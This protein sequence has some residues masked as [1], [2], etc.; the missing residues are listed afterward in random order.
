MKIDLR[1][2]S[3]STYIFKRIYEF[4]SIKNETLE[5]TLSCRMTL[6]FVMVILIS[7]VL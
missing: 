6:S 7:M 3:D 1:L 2:Y 4:D 5:E